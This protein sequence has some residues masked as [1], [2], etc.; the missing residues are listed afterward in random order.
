MKE[1]SIRVAKLNDKEKVLRLL[2]DVFNK[3]QRS[4]GEARGDKFWNW[5]FE[6]NIFGKAIV[7]IIESNNEILAVGTMWP[8]QFRSGVT[9]L[10]A[11]Q[12]CDTVVTEKARGLG[13]FNLLNK[14]RIEFANKSKV[15]FLF[16]FPNKNSMPG[17]LNMGWSYLGR[18]PWHVKVLKPYTFLKNLSDKNQKL[19]ISIPK[20]MRID[21]FDFSDYSEEEYKKNISVNKINGFYDWRYKEHPSREYGI[22]EN[23]KGSKKSFAI[24]TLSGKENLVEMIIT[25]IFCQKGLE[26]FL[27]KKIIETA[28]TLNV[29]IIYMISNQ[30]FRKISLL[31]R[32]FVTVRNKNLVCLPINLT[33]ENKLL[34]MEKWDLFA[35][36]H[37][38]I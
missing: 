23:I 8:W 29:S 21:F 31:R 1:Y 14:K 7:H 6:N 32:G 3:Q 12:L 18:L 5:K 17:Y 35:G 27:L 34:N 2:D 20:D 10:N 19:K 13:L 11:Y 15:D 22:A 37:D 28:R 26:D 9:L 24:F 38:S 33:I 36:M 25:D 30:K 16:N 4:V